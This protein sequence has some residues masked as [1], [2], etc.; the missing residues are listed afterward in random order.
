LAESVRR[1]LSRSGEPRLARA[2]DEPELRRLARECPM[3]GAVR[4]SVEREPDFF[5]LTRLQGGNARVLV[6]DDED[7]EGSL[8]AV[9]SCVERTRHFGGALRPFGYL[10]DLKVHPARRRQGL[11][12]ALMDLAREHLQR[13]R[14]TAF[15]VVLGSNA[16]MRSVVTRTDAALRFQ[17]LATVHNFNVFLTVRPSA[18]AGTLVREA[19]ETDIEQLAELWNAVQRKRA[20]TPAL[21]PAEL[22][23]ALAALASGALDHVLVVER[24]R[25]IAGFAA[26]WDPRPIKQVRLLGLSPRLAWLRR[27]YNPVARW[28]G[29]P[30]I[31]SDGG[32]LPF[33]YVSHVCAETAA[34]LRALLAGAHDR[35][36]GSDALY[37]DL[38]LDARDP[39]L[40]ALAGLFKTSVDFDVHLIAPS[41]TR[42]LDLPRAPVYFEMA[43]A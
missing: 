19:R 21:G 1:A 22:R 28:L 37:L 4:Y 29:R 24:D 27:A 12:R 33:V 34:D 43:H 40:G 18:P 30:T 14:L 20:L 10:A 41:C 13:E 42:E 3:I 7:R 15:G 17:R 16:S 6:M 23:A 11:A 36:A 39:L 8:S 9:A 5:A 26:L 25:R 31:P 2:T 38:A 32:V 35:L